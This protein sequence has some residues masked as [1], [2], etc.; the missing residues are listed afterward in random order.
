MKGIIEWFRSFFPKSNL[1]INYELAR[2]CKDA[3][4]Q[5][6]LIARDYAIELRE[7]AENQLQMDLFQQALT[8]MFTAEQIKRFFDE[9][10]RLRNEHEN[11]AS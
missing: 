1:D 4:D 11:N 2:R 5:K 10:D 8:N 3:E 7:S 9:T 6:V